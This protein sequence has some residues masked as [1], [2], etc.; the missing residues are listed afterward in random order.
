MII[1]GKLRA[2]G[3][4][5]NAP[6]WSFWIKDIPYLCYVIKREGI[7]PK[8]KKLQGIM[9]LRRPTTTT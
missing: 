6:K 5:V 2:A 9:Y 1:Y 3:S 8:P 4:T 7:K